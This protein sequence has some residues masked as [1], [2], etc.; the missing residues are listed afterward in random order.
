MN[1]QMQFWSGKKIEIDWGKKKKVD[2]QLIMINLPL[3]KKKKV[4]TSIHIVL[5]CCSSYK[6]AKFTLIWHLFNFEFLHMYKFCTYTFAF[7]SH[8]MAAKSRLSVMV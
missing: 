8:L 4:V 1:H 5:M 2:K 7:V 6:F 3:R